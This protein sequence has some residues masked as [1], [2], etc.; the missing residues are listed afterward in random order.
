MCCGC[1]SDL[2]IYGHPTRSQDDAN[3]QI[4]EYLVSGFCLERSFELAGESKFS[5]QIIIGSRFNFGT[6]NGVSLPFL[7]NFPKLKNLFQNPSIGSGFQ[8]GFN[9]QPGNR[10]FGVNGGSNILG[11]FG[12]QRGFNG[13]VD[14]QGTYR[15]GFGN[16]WSI[17]RGLVDGGQNFGGSFNPRTGEVGFSRS[18]GIGPFFNAERGIKLDFG[19]LILRREGRI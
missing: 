13:E 16:N 2:G 5:F 10:G 9:N 6:S 3:L 11:M 1:K 12:Q 17:M 14:S 19:D 8:A 4:H 15:G 18:G 7:S